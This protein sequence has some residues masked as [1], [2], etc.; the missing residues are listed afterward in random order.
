MSRGFQA[1]AEIARPP[2]EVWRAMTDFAWAP[3]WM[4]G[5]SRVAALND[6]PV[7]PGKR[8][9]VAFAQSGRG[10]STI[11]TLAEWDPGRMV[12]AFASSQSGLRTHY[13]YSLR[14]SAAGTAAT[15]EATSEARAP[16]MKLMHPLLNLL[17]AKH[18]SRQM[19][20]LKAMLEAGG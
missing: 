12:F 1:T 5:V 7:G 8:Y 9:E 16:V 14:S 17:M 20:L 13:R 6:D 11:S 15:L 2:A 4:P 10:K 19:P 18:D 3:A